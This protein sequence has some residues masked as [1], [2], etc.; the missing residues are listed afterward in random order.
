MVQLLPECRLV[1]SGR[2]GFSLSSDWD[3]HAYLLC[4]D[5]EAVL[6]DTGSGRDVEAT[7]DRIARSLGGRD[8]VAIVLTHAHV[9]HS[10][11]AAALSQRFG[12]S[13]YAHPVAREWLA[14]GD[15]DAVGLSEARAAGVYPPDQVLRPV[16]LVRGIEDSITV[17]GLELRAH[18]TPGHSLDHVVY[19]AELDA[20]RAMF[21]GDLVF[22]QG[23][24][25][26]LDTHDTDVVRY[27]ESIRAMNELAPDMLF[28]GH[29]AVVLARGGAHLADAVAAYDRGARPM[30]LLA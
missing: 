30:G 20:G 25:A 18:R 28:P 17:D 5:S 3:S 24:V 22:A 10:G 19:T 13:V 6:I 12:S 4:G 29:G 27:E 8:L 23:R 16:P 7:A 2:L 26:I 1:A 11:G 21:S 14:T 9:D 15:E